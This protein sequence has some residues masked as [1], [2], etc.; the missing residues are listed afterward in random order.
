MS[1]CSLAQSHSND[2]VLAIADHN[3]PVIMYNDE[4]EGGG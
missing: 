2:S 4:H 1:N 3:G